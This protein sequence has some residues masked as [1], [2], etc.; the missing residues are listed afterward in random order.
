MACHSVRHLAVRREHFT[1]GACRTVDE[2]VRP[3]DVDGFACGPERQRAA[4][5]RFDNK[6]RPAGD[7]ALANVDGRSAVVIDRFEPSN[8]RSGLPSNLTRRR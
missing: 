6:V 5:L 1:D 4:G 8:I 2:N 7:V 3:N